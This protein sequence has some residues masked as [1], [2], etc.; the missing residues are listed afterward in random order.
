MNRK[1]WLLCLPIALI[2]ASGVAAL[3]PLL[4]SDDHASSDAARLQALATEFCVTSPAE[5]RAAPADKPDR[6]FTAQ[7]PVDTPPMGLQSTTVYS[8][9]K[10][11]VVQFRVSSP[12]SGLVAVHGLLDV[13]PVAAG[14]VVTVS[15]RAIYSGRFALHFHGID[16]SHFEIAAVEV[17]PGLTTQPQANAR[18]QGS[19][20]GG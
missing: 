4:H 2:G 7:V 17:Q 11:D 6:L 19:S 20:S 16:G 12:R 10:G 5:A 14:G 3:S 9:A 18:A 8:I 1:R 15:F 13:E